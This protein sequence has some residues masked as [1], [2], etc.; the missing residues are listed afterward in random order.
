MSR[1]VQS[2]RRPCPSHCMGLRCGCGRSEGGRAGA[3]VRSVTVCG[4]ERTGKTD[5]RSQGGV[6]ERLVS[7]HLARHAE[8]HAVRPCECGTSMLRT[9]NTQCTVRSRCHL[10]ALLSVEVR[11]TDP[12]LLAATIHGHLSTAF[13]V[14]F[15]CGRV[16]CVRGV[17]AC[18]CMLNFSKRSAML[19]QRCC[20]M[21]YPQHVTC[22]YAHLGMSIVPQRQTCVNVATGTGMC[23]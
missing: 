13:C 5:R 8:W 2:R 17:E 3:L 21:P 10:C 22:M 23:M 11:S 12:F 14:W 4:H 9:G 1:P 19:Q 20:G 6:F 16:P 15:S 18:G 7:T